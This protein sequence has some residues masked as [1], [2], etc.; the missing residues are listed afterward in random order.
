LDLSNRAPQ[1][2]A[3]EDVVGKTVLLHCEGGFGDA[4]QFIRYLPMVKEKGAKVL[5]E[6]QKDLKELFARVEGIDGLFARGE[7][8]PGFDC[9]CPLQGLPLRLGTMSVE[10]IPAGIPYLSAEAGLVEKWK[11]NVQG[12]GDGLKVGLVW[13]GSGSV[14]DRRSRTLETFA[15]LGKIKGVRYVSM[16]KGKEAEE[17]KRAAELGLN[18]ADFLE[19]L[20]DFAQAAGLVQNL[21]LVITVD[22]AAAHLAGAMGKEAWVLLPACPDFRWML[23]REDSPWYPG[24]MRLFRKKHTESWADVIERVAVALRERVK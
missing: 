20:T 16:Q 19:E 14:L 2:E 15:P 11:E 22:T 13:A 21:D 10:E 17:A 1:W 8:L 18:L 23:E 7:E 9:H 4:L 24:V 3:G 6:C 12:L 5:L